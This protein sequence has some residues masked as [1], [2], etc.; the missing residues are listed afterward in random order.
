MA[1]GSLDDPAPSARNLEA[2]SRHLG[3]RVEDAVHLREY[4]A[5]GPTLP[6]A[7]GS[8]ARRYPNHPALT[9]DEL[10]LTHAEV[11]LAAHQM[12]ADLQRLG[13]RSGTGVVVVADTDMAVMLAYLG[14]LRSGVVTTFAHRS[15]TAS[16]LADVVGA[17]NAKY[18]LATGE[19]LG[20][21]SE[22]SVGVRTIGL[23]DS[24]RESI[25]SLPG[26]ALANPERVSVP[27]D[28]DST[29]IVAFTSGS[30]G[31]PK[32]VP[33][34]HRNLLTSIRG[35]MSAWRW[36][37]SDRLV[38]SL[39]IGHQHGLGG[40]HAALLSGSHTIVLPRFDTAR[41]ITTVDSENATVL[42]AVPAIYDRMLSE[43]PD[44]LH[45]FAALRLMISG[46]APLP[47]DVAV[48]VEEM[49]GQMPLERYG[50]TEA[51]LDVSNPYDGP[52]LPGTV[53]LPLPG[54][55]MALIDPAGRLVDDGDTGEVVLRGPQVF[56]GYGGGEDQPFVAGWFR[57]G[58]LAVVDPPTGYL[59]LLGR[60]KEVI[61]T[62]GMN[63][64]PSEVERALR[65]VAGVI[66]AAVIGT[67]SRRWGEAVTAFV[68]MR[69]GT[70]ADVAAALESRLAPFKRPKAIIEL[71][72]IPRTRMGK[73][74]RESLESWAKENSRATDV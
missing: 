52:R 66:D 11:E 43:A 20:R 32:P 19:S 40:I 51:G 59:R 5:A 68:V 71:E 36:S 44:Q 26:D 55:E 60:T 30:T 18:V 14:A 3:Y 4:L 58:D 6:A 63:V 50:S 64:Y 72:A 49:T 23:K 10:T 25:Q 17:V 38:H 31:K 53:G 33:L 15:S 47:P 62:G 65:D 9:V 57:T 37:A 67:P 42:F 27:T 39:P 34:S 45:R 1:D 35:A 2:W 13:V 54:V 16:E 22:A 7:F 61:I 46:S 29:A 69:G 74:R 24:D 73:L 56:G 70:S 12:A 48:D 21:L 41:L 28:P 8:V